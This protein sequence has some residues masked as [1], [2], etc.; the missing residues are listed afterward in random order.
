[1]S[2]QT[3]TWVAM[4]W[5]ALAL[6]TFALLFF[7]VAPFGRHTTERWGPTIDNRLGWVLMELPSLSIMVAFLVFG[8]HA[9]TG[10]TWVLFALWIAHY[11]NR[12]FVFPLRIRTAG[13]RMPVIIVLSA[14]LFNVINAGLNG[15]W[16]A[17]FAP[18]YGEDWL[19]SP[20]F[21]TGLALFVVGAWINLKSDNM[22]IALRAPSET[23][24]TIPRGFLFNYISAP[25]LFG[26]MVEWAGFALMAWNW[27][28]LSFFVWTVANLLPR[29]VA[30]HAWYRARFADYPLERKA[31]IPFVL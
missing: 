2:A 23:G 7:V 29:A 24:Y 26:E 3:L 4:V 16:L 25:N 15:Y 17:E 18:T 27:P 11:A 30:H 28:A 1:M 31:A 8:T 5:T 20:S 6:P 10:Y 19:R 13:K 14:V 21:M 9:R 22:L 12:V